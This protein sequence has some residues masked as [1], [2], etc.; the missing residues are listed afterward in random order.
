MRRR[1]ELDLELVGIAT[2]RAAWL[3]SDGQSVPSLLAQL[4][5]RR[6]FHE[7]DSVRPGWDSA[8]TIAAVEADVLVEA[9]PTNFQ[10]GEPAASLL[11]L[12]LARG[13]SAAAASKGALVQHY[14]ELR[15]LARDSGGHLRFGAATAAALP[16]VDLA[17]YCLAGA[18]ITRVEG[19]LNGT[20]NFILTMMAD[21]GV[22]FAAALQQAQARGIAE[23]DP[24][25]DIDGWD[26][27][28]KLVLIAN[29]VWDAGLRLDQ[30]S[31]RGI[32]Q[33]TAAEIRHAAG[34]RRVLK[35][36][37]S[38]WWE[39]DQ[40]R[41]SVELRSLSAEHPLAHV[42]GAEKGT[43]FFTDTMDRVAVLGGVSD[44][45]GAAAAL[46]R[47]VIHLAKEA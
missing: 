4:H 32:R 11:R 10:D 23:S 38:L 45:V 14:A 33:V 15:D 1:Y 24:T 17:R 43:V 28:G 18:S 13:W 20:T 29:A 16:T 35:L 19:I 30:V 41:A 31:V 25:L 5:R 9:T 36:I 6:A 37:G 26:T 22:S 12:A 47:D 39:G 27:A 8:R 7:L 2:A 34:Y 21:H 46:L 42:N 44:P 3:S 40:L